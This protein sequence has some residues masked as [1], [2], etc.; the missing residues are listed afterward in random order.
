MS[1]QLLPRAAATMVGSMPHRD[2][3]KIIDLI[4]TKLSDV[5]VWPQLASYPHEQMME[6]Y[7]EG[8]PGVQKEGDRVFVCT[9]GEEFHKELYEFYEE[10]LTIMDKPESIVNSH[11]FGFGEDTGK[12]FSLFL[13]TLRDMPHFVAIKGQVVGPFT[14]LSGMKDHHDRLLLYDERMADIV[15]KHL[16][17]KGLWQAIKLKNFAERVIIFYDEPALAGFGSSAFISVS[18]DFVK[19][20]VTEL[21]SLL[22]SLGILVGIHVCANTDWSI[23]LTSSIDIV[24]FDAYNFNDKFALYWADAIN[25]LQRNGLIAWGLIPTDEEER[26]FSETP[27]RLRDKMQ[28]FFE[29]LRENGYE[30]DEKWVLE[31][32][33]ITPSCGCGT[34]SER[35]SERVVDLLCETSYYVRGHFGL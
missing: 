32:S 29:G 24:N 5:P 28:G 1:S 11:R 22:K 21:C 13:D 16:V 15:A 9:E 27:E 35:A 12:T 31:R 23:L 17:M 33:L 34:L 26:V 3:K 4:L 7:L 10:Y 2:R 6:Q 20:L 8:L 30:L 19:G 18:E 25:F 14:L